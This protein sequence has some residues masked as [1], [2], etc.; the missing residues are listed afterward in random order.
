MCSTWQTITDCPPTW[1]LFLNI[2]V[3]YADV[4]V[5]QTWTVLA[6][7]VSLAWSLTSY[8]RSVRYS[9]DDKEKMRWNGTM[10]NFCWQLMSAGNIKINSGIKWFKAFWTLKIYCGMIPLCE[11]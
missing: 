1:G 3:L 2:A 5:L 9:R 7:I 6:A 8:H 4:A 10:V 11:N